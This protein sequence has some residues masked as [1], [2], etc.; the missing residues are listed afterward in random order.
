[1]ID[2]TLRVLFHTVSSSLTEITSGALECTNGAQCFT[3]EHRLGIRNGDCPVL[4][5]SITIILRSDNH[6]GLNMIRNKR[7]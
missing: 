6:L 5:S 4:I 2:V 7:I 1:M 3:C